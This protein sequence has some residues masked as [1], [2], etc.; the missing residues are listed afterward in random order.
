M[1]FLKHGVQTKT[2]NEYE[3]TIKL[4]H[5]IKHCS[6]GNILRKGRRKKEG[7]EEES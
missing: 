6:D 5:R 2:T 3:N 7:K 4:L 1:F